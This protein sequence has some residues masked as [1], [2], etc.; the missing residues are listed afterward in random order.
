MMNVRAISAAA[1][2]VC[3]AGWISPALAQVTALG[4]LNP[5]DAA[6]FNETVAMGPVDVAGTFDVTTGAITA[7]SATIAVTSAGEYTPGTLWV[8]VNTGTATMPVLGMLVDSDMLTKVGSEYTASLSDLLAAGDYVVTIT[9][10]VNVRDLG[11]GGSVTTS[12]IPEA[13]TW[14]MMG[15]GFAGLG[16]VGF[17]TRRKGER[18]VVL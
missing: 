18:H 7:T 12:T 3:G 10:T 17:V 4:N 13:P 11:V 5:D 15:L 16:A 6:S 1:L 14:A 9:G 2:V 8:N